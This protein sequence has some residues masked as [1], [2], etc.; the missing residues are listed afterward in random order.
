MRVGG[1]EFQLEEGQAGVFEEYEKG[2]VASKTLGLPKGLRTQLE[3]A[4]TFQT[5]GNL[6]MKNENN[7]SGLKYTKHL[8]CNAAQNNY[9]LNAG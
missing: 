9:S 1:R 7:C 5:W 6:N 2:L 8:N 3:E 4:P